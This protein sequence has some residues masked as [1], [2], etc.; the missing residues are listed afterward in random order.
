MWQWLKCKLGFHSGIIKDGM[1]RCTRCSYYDLFSP[2]SIEEAISG[3]PDLDRFDEDEI[4]MVSTKKR[5]G[6]EIE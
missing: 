6:G 2:K 4:I 3:I 5:N 1:F